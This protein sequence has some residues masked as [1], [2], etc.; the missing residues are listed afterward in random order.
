[1]LAWLSIP[2]EAEDGGGDAS[3]RMGQAVLEVIKQAGLKPPDV[4]RVGL[5]SPGTMDIP[6][7]MLLDPPN[8]PGWINFPLRDRVSEHCGLPVAFAND[9]GAAA[10]GEFWIGSGRDVNSLVLFTL[11]TGIGCGIIVDGIS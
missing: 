9:A 6:A 2:T 5:G 8:L 10:F 3:R 4:A 11:G 7:G 1:S